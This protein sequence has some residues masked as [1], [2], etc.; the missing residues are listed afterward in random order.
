M[1][2]DLEQECNVSLL[3]RGR[4]GVVLTSS[5]MELF[6]Y[7]VNLCQEFDKLQMKIDDMNGIQSGIIR[8]GTFSSVATHWLPNII[9]VFEQ[10]YPNIEF[11]LLMGDYEEIEQWIADGR[12]DFGFLRLPTHKTFD[13]IELQ[14][15][16]QMVVLP[17]DHPLAHAEKFPVKSLQDDPFIM[18]EKGTKAEITEI[19]LKN[20]LTPKPKY[21]TFDDYAALSMVEKGLGIA[22]LPKLIL[23]RVSYDVVVKPLDVEAYRTIGVAMKSEKELSLAAQRFLEYLDCREGEK[24]DHDEL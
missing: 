20:G 16:Q 18:L 9:A 11:E 19:Y 17:K 6:P 1:I 5:G 3:Q 10:D 7:A 14:K 8:I 21:T 22:I 12:V 4:Q 23:Q 24:E 13:T 15:D 2:A